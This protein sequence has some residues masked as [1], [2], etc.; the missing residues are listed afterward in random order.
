MQLVCGAQP[1]AQPVPSRMAFRRR[2]DSGSAPPNGRRNAEPELEKVS[3][4]DE[5]AGFFIVDSLRRVLAACVEGS[6]QDA[7]V[8]P[9]LRTVPDGLLRFC[10]ARLHVGVAPAV[11]HVASESVG[12]LSRVQLKVRS[13]GNGRVTER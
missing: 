4:T 2:T 13:T 3:L 7:K 9:A 10:F 12:I 1:M 11:R 6:A 8:H 5:S